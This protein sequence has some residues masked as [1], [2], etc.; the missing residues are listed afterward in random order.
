MALTKK[1]A[2]FNKEIGDWTI[3][4]STNARTN[5]PNTNIES[6]IELTN[7]IHNPREVSLVSGENKNNCLNH[8]K[9]N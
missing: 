1:I 6:I 4:K 7:N 9:N 3:Q 2:G 5:H 8:W